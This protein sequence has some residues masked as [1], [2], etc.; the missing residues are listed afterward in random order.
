MTINATELLPPPVLARFEQSLA[1]NRR[2]VDYLAAEFRSLNEGFTRAG[3][4]YAAI[5]GF[6][7]V[8]TYCPDAVLLAPSDLDYLV[9]KPFLPVAQRVLEFAIFVGVATLA[10]TEQTLLVTQLAPGCHYTPRRSLQQGNHFRLIASKLAVL[11]YIDVFTPL[12]TGALNDAIPKVWAPAQR[13]AILSLDSASRSQ[14]PDVA[15]RWRYLLKVDHAEQAVRIKIRTR[16]EE[17][18][19]GVAVLSAALSEGQ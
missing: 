5:K 18:L 2:R 8:P 3:L 17:Q 6:S 1:N 9:D 4:N 14:S 15:N 16:G 7:L 13:F 19:I 11:S 12:S 10:G